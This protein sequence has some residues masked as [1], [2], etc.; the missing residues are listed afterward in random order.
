MANRYASDRYERRYDEDNYR[1]DEFERHGRGAGREYGDRGYRGER[2]EFQPGRL[3]GR[4]PVAGAERSGMEDYNRAAGGYGQGYYGGFGREG[5]MF[6]QSTGRHDIDY[7]GKWVDEYSR[8]SYEGDYEGDGREYGNLQTYGE[9]WRDEA[10]RAARRGPFAGRGPRGYRRSDERIREE[11][12][13]RLTDHGD[14]D[15]SDIEVNV[16][17]GEV[18]LEGFVDSRQT[19]RLAEDLAESVSGVRDVINHLRVAWR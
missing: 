9:G 13:D 19:K 8:G 18:V 2:Q 14:I 15:A 1:R 6:G 3:R 7:G 12:N 17:E 16:I 5:R 10:A 11:V 4:T